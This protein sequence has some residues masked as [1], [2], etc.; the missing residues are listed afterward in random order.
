MNW[1]AFGLFLDI[2]G[3]FLILGHALYDYG[4]AAATKIIDKVQKNPNQHKKSECL[5]EKIKNNSK[6]TSVEKEQL[7]EI[8]KENFTMT[9]VVWVVNFWLWINR[10]LFHFHPWTEETP[11]LTNRA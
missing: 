8:I 11:R 10:I 1:T 6:L 9:I 5:I 7:V 4:M 2:C 3:A